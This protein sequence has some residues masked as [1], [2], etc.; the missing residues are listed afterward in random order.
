MSH[1]NL[2]PQDRTKICRCLNY[3]KLTRETCKQLARNPKIP[4]DVAV[5]ALKSSCENQEHRTQ[6]VKLVNKSTCRSRRHSQDK[7]HVMLHLKGFEISEK[8]AE[9]LKT[10]GGYNWKVMDSFREGL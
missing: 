2:T 1:S 3:K 5:Q 10:K 7:K 9:E 8:L 6:E 4:P